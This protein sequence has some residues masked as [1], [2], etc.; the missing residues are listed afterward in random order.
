MGVLLHY[1]LDRT[2]PCSASASAPSVGALTTHSAIIPVFSACAFLSAAAKSFYCLCSHQI[3]GAP[4]KS[5]T[6]NPR[7][8]A[9]LLLHGHLHQSIDLHASCSKIIPHARVRLHHHISKLSHVACNK[10]SLAAFTRPFSVIMCRH[11]RKLSGL[12]SAL[13]VSGSDNVASRSNSNPSRSRSTAC[14]AATSARRLPCSPV[15]TAC[16][17][18]ELQIT[19]RTSAGNGS[20]SNSNDLQSRSIARFA[21]APPTTN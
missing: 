1:W 16:F 4:S 15:A 7:S 13:Q 9:I 21:T 5:A 2:P 10:A 11:R 3:H 12:I 19:T 20:N 8:K 17:T 18:I 14:P 6:G